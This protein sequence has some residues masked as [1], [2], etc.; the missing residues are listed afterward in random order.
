[1][2]KQQLESSLFTGGG[3]PFPP[4]FSLIFLKLFLSPFLCIGHTSLENNAH[5]K[6]T[7]LHSII[8]WT[9]SCKANKQQHSAWKLGTQAAGEEWDSLSLPTS[10]EILFSEF[11]K[12]LTR[13]KNIGR[14]GSQGNEH[15]LQRQV[16]P[17]TVFS[18]CTTQQQINCNIVTK[19]KHQAEWNPFL[20]TYNCKMPIYSLKKNTI[21][22]AFR[23]TRLPQYNKTKNKI[24]F[25]L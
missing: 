1:M 2:K 19:N 8:F 6:D 17:S 14:S 5:T 11:Q 24:I 9:L 21:L 4:Q 25:P 16:L 15:H 13:I 10:T 22:V 20:Y 12:D 23:G 18:N 7:H 3:F